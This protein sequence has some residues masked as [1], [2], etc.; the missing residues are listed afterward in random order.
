MTKDEQKDLILAGLAAGRTL[1]SICRE[2]GMPGYAAVR[3]WL[4][5]DEEFEQAYYKARDIGYD[6]RADEV[7]DIVDQPPA[8]VLGK[9]DAGHVAWQKLRADMRLKNLERV[10]PSRYAPRANVSVGN[11]DDK[12]LKVEGGVDT[13]ALTL[14]L[15]AALRGAKGGADE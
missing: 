2:K 1:A 3:Y 8:K 4:E 6:A 11:A 9:I 15:A 7:L 14:Q 13:A 12:P 10:C 5:T